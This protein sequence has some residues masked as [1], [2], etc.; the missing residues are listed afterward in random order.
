[1]KLKIYLNKTFKNSCNAISINVLCS[2]FNILQ[3][4]DKKELIIDGVVI[5]NSN[6]INKIEFIIAGYKNSVD[7]NITTPVVSTCKEYEQNPIIAEATNLNA[8]LEQ[9]K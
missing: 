4:K 2:Y 9:L 5:T 7:L 3:F 6:T 8:I 1:M